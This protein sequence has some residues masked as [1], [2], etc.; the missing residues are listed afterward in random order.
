MFT[1]V[2]TRSLVEWFAQSNPLPD[3]H[4]H[5]ELQDINSVQ[6]Y[7]RNPRINDNAVDAVATSLRE[8][9]FRHRLHLGRLF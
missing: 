7:D 2:K 1:T 6:P 4:M 8:F 5:I 3:F 9:G